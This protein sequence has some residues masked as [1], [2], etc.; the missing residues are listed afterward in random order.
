[1]NHDEYNITSSEFQND[2][3]TVT[4]SSTY[5]QP[6]FRYVSRGD[7]L[8][9]GTVASAGL[10]L[11]VY[12]IDDEVIGTGI[13]AEIPLGWVGLVV[14]RS[15]IGRKGFRLKNTLGVID[16]DYRGEIKLAYEGFRPEPGQRVAQLI[17][18]PHYVGAVERMASID[19]LNNTARGTG[20]FG[21][22]GT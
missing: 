7:D 9:Q 3:A 21:S 6:S 14:P 1:M 2:Y 22:T 5:E 12:S 17:L 20:G 13:F 8:T 10:D 16:S 15:S 4:Q 19:D 11:S 18:V